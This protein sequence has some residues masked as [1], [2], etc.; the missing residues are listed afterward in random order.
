MSSLYESMS[1]LS[2]V[3]MSFDN[4]IKTNT[5]LTNHGD[6]VW[7]LDCQD[8]ASVSFIKVSSILGKEFWKT[9][10]DLVSVNFPNGEYLRKCEISFQL[11]VILLSNKPNDKK[12]K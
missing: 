5:S 1:S 3:S 12:T 2:W 9:N 6:T 10:F 11:S 8:K 7:W 4:V